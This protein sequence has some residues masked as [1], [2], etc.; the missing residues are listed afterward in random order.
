MLNGVEGEPPEEALR[1]NLEYLTGEARNVLGLSPEDIS[2]EEI[3]ETIYVIRSDGLVSVH[4]LRLR[5]KA[6]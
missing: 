4:D 6:K 3:Q 1:L 2:D 5:E